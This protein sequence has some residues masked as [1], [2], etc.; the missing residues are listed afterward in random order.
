M[1]R[2]KAAMFEVF[3]HVDMC[4][5]SYWSGHISR[6][7]ILIKLCFLSKHDKSTRNSQVSLRCCVKK[8][9]TDGQTRRWKT[10]TNEPRTLCA[11]KPQLVINQCI[12][13]GRANT[14]TRPPNK[15]LL[16]DGIVQIIS[17]FDEK[18]IA[19][20]LRQTNK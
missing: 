8:K 17:H 14:H 6:I 4:I 20:S 1:R 18:E 5:Q 19:K 7:F 3:A 12:T 11:C 2:A 9:G 13:K 10:N 16:D 15:E